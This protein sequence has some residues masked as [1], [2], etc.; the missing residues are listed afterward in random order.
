MIVHS[1]PGY[2]TSR[3]GVLS[4]RFRNIWYACTTACLCAFGSG[5][6]SPHAAL[7]PSVVF[8]EVPSLGSSGADSTGVLRGH[9]TG[10]HTGKRIVL[11]ALDGENWW[12]QPV[13][14][15]PFTE[16]AADG[17]WSSP[18]HLGVRYAALLVNP[19]YVPPNQMEQLPAT[20]GQIDAVATV[21][22]NKSTAPAQHLRFS[23]YDWEVRQIGSDRNG[24]PHSYKPTNVSIDSHGFLHLLISRNPA[25]GWTCSEIALPRSLGYGTYEFLVDDISNLDPAAVLSLFTWDAKGTDQNRREIDFV[26][27]QWGNRKQSNAQYIVQ[28]YYRPANTY[29]YVAPAGLLNYSFRWDPARVT[30]TTSRSG[31][32]IAEH[33][34]T[35]DVPVPK[36]ES[37]HMNL[38]TFDYTPTPQGQ[39]AEIIVQRF[40]FLP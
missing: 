27:S 15:H 22:P 9:V 11:Y 21:A 2:S 24:S 17:S 40:Q 8:E 36:T 29:R 16:I 32:P 31:R 28:P 39:P 14:I 26:I 35:A 23:N 33:T 6:R 10:P 30:F 4:S 38:C 13:T 25:G 19:G 5:C 3:A 37:V 7:Q 12:I 18:T 1:T 34:F 20:G